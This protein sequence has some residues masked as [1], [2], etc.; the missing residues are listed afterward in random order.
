MKKQIKL[1]ILGSFLSL[2]SLNTVSAQSTFKKADKIVEGTVSYTKSTDVKATWS[3]N[4]TVG[5]F[6]TDK[7]AVGLSA[8]VGEAGETKTTNVGVF[9]RY[10]V[11]NL[12]KGI[13][14]YSQLDLTNNTTGV[15][16]KSTSSFTSNVGL[17]AN[18]FVTKNLALS[19]GLANLISYQS[20]DSKSTFSVGFTGINNPISAAKFGLL[21]RF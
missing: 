14:V 18:Y 9:G 8:Q 7:I 19:M 3:L 2:L 21:Y 10:Y 13:L 5:Y 16:G 15:S 12:C 11:L 6:V 1:T 4:P 17:G 20:V